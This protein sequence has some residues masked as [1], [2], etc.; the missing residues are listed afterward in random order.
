MSFVAEKVGFA[1]GQEPVEVGDN[2]EVKAVVQGLLGALKTPTEKYDEP[3]TSS[4]EVG[5]HCRPLVPPNPRF[6]H[7]VRSGPETAFA[8]TY[9]K[10]MAGEHMFHGKSGKYLSF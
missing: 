6:M 3:M 8:Q 4:Q 5:W 1:T 10:K 2:P 7:G 9:T